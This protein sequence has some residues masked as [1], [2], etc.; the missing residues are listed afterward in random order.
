MSYERSTVARNELVDL[1]A[2]LHEVRLKTWHE[3][4]RLASPLRLDAGDI[5]CGIHDRIAE[6]ETEVA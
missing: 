2:V 1:A 6:L 5:R 4:A 3:A